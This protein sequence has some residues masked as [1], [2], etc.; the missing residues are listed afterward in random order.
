[1]PHKKEDIYKFKLD[2]NLMEEVR[3]FF[4]Y[5][6][7]NYVRIIYSIEYYF[8]GFRRKYINSSACNN[9]LLFNLFSKK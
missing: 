5:L 1:M 8:L 3:G 4:D 9:I 7:I 6:I 2:Y